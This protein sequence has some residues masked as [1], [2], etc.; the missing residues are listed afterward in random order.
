MTKS[1]TKY[2]FRIRLVSLVIIS[3][4]IVLCGKL[5]SVQ[6]LQ[7]DENRKKLRGL[8]IVKQ[9]KSLRHFTGELKQI[10]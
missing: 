5:F 10:R 4:W 2:R 1:F 9:S 6:I 8:K 7:A 3:F